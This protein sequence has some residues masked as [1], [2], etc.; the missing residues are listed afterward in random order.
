ME[1]QAELEISGAQIIGKLSNRC[2]REIRGR[3]D[4]QDQLV[5][6]QH[7]DTLMT[8]HSSLITNV[9]SYFPIDVMTANSQLPL[10]RGAVHAF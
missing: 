6:N 4:L 10:H 9:D 1:Y 7:V 3:L 2:G 5:V 8:E